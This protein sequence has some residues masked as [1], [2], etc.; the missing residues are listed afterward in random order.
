MKLAGGEVYPPST[1]H[2]LL[3][4]SSREHNSECPNLLDKRFGRLQG[5][6]DSYIHKLHSQGIGRN[7]KH[8]ERISANEE[9][10]LWESGVLNTPTPKG[11]QNAVFYAIGKIFCLRGGQEHRALRLSQLQ[12]DGEK[13]VTRRMFLRVEVHLQQGGSSVSLYRSIRKVPSPPA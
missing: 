9:N 4:K 13:Y 3:C 1:L 6:L 5:T 2:Q 11:L 10:Q 12:R 8:A 7:A